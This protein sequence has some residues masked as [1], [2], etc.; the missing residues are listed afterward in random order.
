MPKERVIRRKLADGT[1]KE[2]RYTTKKTV[3]T[4]TVEYRESAE[5]DD[6]A[7]GTRR[8]YEVYLDMIGS[9]Y[10]D[11]SVDAI[12]LSHVL[13]MRD[14]HR[15]Q[16]AT[17]N[18]V[19][20]V[21]SILLSFAMRRGYIKHHPMVGARVKKLKEGSYARWS[22]EAV[23]FALKNLPEHLA[24]AAMFGVYTGQRVSDCIGRRWSEIE[25]D[26]FNMVQQKTGAELWVP[27]H[28]DLKAA[29][30]E[31]KTTARSVTILNK[32]DG[33]PWASRDSFKSAFSKAMSRHPELNGLVFHG[34][35]KSAAARLAEAGCSEH[36]IMAITGHRTLAEVQRYTR[37]ARQKIMA[38]SAMVKLSDYLKK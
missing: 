36:E 19:F 21:W 27:L 15:D 11:V 33:L 1:Y 5:W 4:V 10:W 3:G 12:D 2:Y 22:E 29:L 20:A 25:D 18:K 26:G 9:S 32:A 35:R 37:Q 34:L 7:A 6:L 24:R 8:A 28:S 23:V 13:R 30:K 38:K 31:W 16:P 14:A 17:A